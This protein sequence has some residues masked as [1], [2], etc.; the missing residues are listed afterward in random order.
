MTTQMETEI[1]KII[2][3]NSPRAGKYESLKSSKDIINLFLTTHNINEWTGLFDKNGKTIFEGD[4][5]LVF[6]KPSKI[7][8]ELGS[9]CYQYQIEGFSGHFTN[10]INRSMII[11][12]SHFRCLD[13]EKIN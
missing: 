2:L 5:V 10:P 9:F 3:S 1:Q 8:W 4:E 12:D 11:I 7:V 13:I 6:G